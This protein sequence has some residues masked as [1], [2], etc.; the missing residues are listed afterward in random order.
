MHKG[1]MV[2]DS[3]LISHRSDG[4]GALI[5]T[6]GLNDRLLRRQTIATFGQESTNGGVIAESNGKV[7]RLG[8]GLR[9]AELS[10]EVSAN[11]PIGLVGNHRLRVDLIKES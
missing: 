7:V 4:R 1:H 9:A 11:G 10:Q 6:G 3:F 2:F 5:S 8:S